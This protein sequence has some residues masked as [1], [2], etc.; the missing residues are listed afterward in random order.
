M[1]WGVGQPKKGYG[2]QYGRWMENDI[3]RLSAGKS[4]IIGIHIVYFLDLCPESRPIDRAC[5]LRD[6]AK[7]SLNARVV[8]HTEITPG[9]EETVQGLLLATSIFLIPHGTPYKEQYWSEL[10]SIGLRS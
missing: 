6:S 9:T 7:F 10:Q 2:Y 5:A 8:G 3:S 1:R 4:A